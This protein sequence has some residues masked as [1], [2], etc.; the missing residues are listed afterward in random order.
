ME[1][2]VLFLQPLTES[3]LA[4]ICHDYPQVTVAFGLLTMTRSLLLCFEIQQQPLQN[5]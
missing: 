3:F 4:V 1:L 2:A 5:P